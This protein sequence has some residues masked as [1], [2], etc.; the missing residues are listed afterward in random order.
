MILTRVH[1]APL[2]SLE[3]DDPAT[4]DRLLDYY[5]P[6]ADEWLR[7]NLVASLSGSAAGYDGTS[8]TLT[9]KTDRRI[10]GVIRELSDAVLVGAASVRVE[11]YQ[12]PRRSRLAVVTASGDLSGH[13]LDAADAA[14]VTVVCGASA[15][16]RVRETLGDAEI[17]TVPTEH[18]RIAAPDIVAALRT[19]G[20]ASIVCEGGPGLAAQLVAASLV[21]DVCLTTSPVLGEV[22]L[23]I[24]D[25]EGLPERPATLQSLMLDEA[26]FLFARWSLDR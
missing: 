5:R 10:L 16:D 7:L 24:L 4:R 19:A 11:G 17:L 9:S 25:G 26:S 15:V 21:D 6:A 20:Y 14:L 18:G 3:L 1:P 8:E 12:L 2:E 23:P 22:R 13:R